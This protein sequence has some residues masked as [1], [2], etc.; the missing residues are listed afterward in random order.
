MFSAKDA[1]KIVD[2]KNDVKKQIYKVI[3][4]SI[5]S[6]IKNAVENG[7]TGLTVTIPVFMLGYPVYDRTITCTYIER[8][9]CNLGFQTTK[10]TQHDIYVTWVKDKSKPREQP[11]KDIPPP[12][13]NLHKYADTIRKQNQ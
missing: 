2:K 12:F 5:L 1:L 6:K 3:L 13:V 11:V 8:Q 4:D 10:Y 9:L 7:K